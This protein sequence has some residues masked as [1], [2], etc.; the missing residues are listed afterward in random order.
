[1]SG[2][3]GI[4]RSV[5]RLPSR[6]LIGLVRLYQLTL[7]PLVGGHCRYQPTCSAY[8]IQAVQ[9][10]GFWIGAGKGVWRILR[11][12]PLARGGYDPVE[13]AGASDVG[14]ARKTAR[15]KQRGGD[16]DDSA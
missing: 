9:K 8:F 4:F 16:V 10:H 5:L 2:A 12:H 11:C 7:S 15:G 1:M 6:G 13:K 3:A 14:K